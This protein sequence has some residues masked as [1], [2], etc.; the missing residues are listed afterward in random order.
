MMGMKISGTTASLAR[1]IITLKY[2]HS[3]MLIFICSAISMSSCIFVFARG[4]I[5]TFLAAKFCFQMS[6]W[7]A[8]YFSASA[9]SQELPNSG[10]S[11]QLGSALLGACSAIEIYQSFEWFTTNNTNSI[12]AFWAIIRAWIVNGKYLSAF[13][14]I[15]LEGK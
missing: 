9:T 8:E 15:P 11:S 13:F 5:M 12:M 2:F 4:K 3:P 7:I 10:L 6:T 14:A 1:K